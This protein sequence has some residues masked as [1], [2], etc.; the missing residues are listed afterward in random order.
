MTQVIQGLLRPVGIALASTSINLPRTL[1]SVKAGP[2]NDGD[3]NSSAQ[4]TAQGVLKTCCCNYHRRILWKI[5]MCGC[6]FSPVEPSA[7]GHHFFSP[8]SGSLGRDNASWKAS[9]AIK[10]QRQS[11]ALT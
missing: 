1:H 8:P 9:D 4:G 10:P 6:L 2:S 3:R 5:C 7:Y 11:I